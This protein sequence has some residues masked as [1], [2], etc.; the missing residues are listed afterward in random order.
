MI[1]AK[2]VIQRP[3]LT[4][5]PT[6]C[7]I[8]EI[9]FAYDQVEN[10]IFPIESFL[11][12]LFDLSSKKPEISVL[13]QTILWLCSVPVSALEVSGDRKCNF[14]FDNETLEPEIYNFLKT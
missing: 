1:G 11:N 12:I 4:L 8:K 6:D 14:Y 9:S 2:W 5:L 13:N 3:S 10:R 7:V